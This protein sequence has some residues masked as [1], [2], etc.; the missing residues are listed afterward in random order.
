MQAAGKA[1]RELAI[2]QNSSCNAY[3]S[4]V[5]SL[6]LE[7]TVLTGEQARYGMASILAYKCSGCSQKIS[8]AASTRV[9]TSCGGKYWSCNLATIWG[10]MATRGG[11][12]HL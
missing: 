1:E 3:Q 8:F 4:K 5:Q 10:Q 12:N 6:F 2:Q 11:F 7:D 9:N